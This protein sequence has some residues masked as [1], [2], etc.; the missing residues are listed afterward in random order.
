MLGRRYFWLLAEAFHLK[1]CLTG[2]FYRAFI[3]NS[4]DV[5]GV[6]VENNS[7]QN[8]PHDLATSRLWQQI[9]EIQFSNDGDGTKGTTN[10]LNYLT[11]KLIRGL[12]A[13][14]LERRRQ[15]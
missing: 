7:F 9:Y 14:S 3:L 12:I 1:P 15:K 4:G 8:T 5:T 13:A 11:A 6:L 2:V 10:G